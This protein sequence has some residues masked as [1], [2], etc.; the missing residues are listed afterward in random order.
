MSGA[1]PGIPLPLVHRGKVR[2]VYSVDDERLLLVASDRVSAFDVVMNEPVPR[3]GEVLTQITAWWL[4]R[5]E[6]D[7]GIEHHLITANPDE[8]V[9]L[10]PELAASRPHWERRGMLVHRTRPVLVECV[11]RGF[12]SGSA[13]REYRDSGTLAGEPLPAGLRESEELAEPIFS[14]ATKALEGHDE[15]ISYARVV[16]ELG[17]ETAEMLRRRALDIYGYGHAL[18]REHGIVLADTKFEFGWSV[19]GGSAQAEA[20]RADAGLANSAPRL[21]LIDEVLTPD[22]SRF[23]PLEHYEVGRGQ[24]SLDKQP[25]RDYLESLEGWT[26]APPPP[27]LPEAVVADTTARYLDIFERLTGQT[28]DA[29]TPPRRANSEPAGPAAAATPSSSRDRR[30]S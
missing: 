11:V 23:W 19:P 16:A 22:S 24:P 30:T 20:G 13:W 15:N 3:K 10:H 18:C 28:L 14:P 7:L 12:L 1:S 4:E 5:L 21:L 9:E 2:E 6:A 26:K 25:V 8:I 17:H 27:P 29:W